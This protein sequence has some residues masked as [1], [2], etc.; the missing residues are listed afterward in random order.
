[1]KLSDVAFIFAFMFASLALA[2][3]GS[4]ALKT[5]AVIARAM[6]TAQEESSPLIREARIEAVVETVRASHAAGEPESVARQRADEMK[7]DWE[8]AIDG[9]RV[10]SHAVGAYID[11]LVL[12]NAGADFQLVDVLPFFVRAVNSYRALASCLATLGAGDVLPVPEF[13]GL[14]PTDWSAQ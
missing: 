6:L 14:I 10:F 1:M 4:S 7:V 2:G 11:A 13:L 5:N 3:C 8:C 12:V 9:H